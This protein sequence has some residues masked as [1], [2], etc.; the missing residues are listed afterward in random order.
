MPTTFIELHKSRSDVHILPFIYNP[1]CPLSLVS[2]PC[3]AFLNAVIEFGYLP[4]D[5]KLFHQVT[6]VSLMNMFNTVCKTEEEL[7]SP[8]N[9][10]LQQYIS[11]IMTGHKINMEHWF[12]MNNHSAGKIA[13]SYTC[14]F[15]DGKVAAIVEMKL[16]STKAHPVLE[17][18]GYFEMML[19][20]EYYNSS[21][22]CV[23]LVTVWNDIMTFYGCLHHFKQH[24]T[25][26]QLGYASIRFSTMEDDIDALASV[27]IQIQHY[28]NKQQTAINV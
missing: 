24:T 20:R 18:F 10:I 13:S 17:A 22:L 23:L 12:D 19:Q 6:A 26:E 8:F 25:I 4:L 3:I 2:E 9:S 28:R 27:A 1:K 21:K 15:V 14:L 16:L 7:Y 11:T 5:D